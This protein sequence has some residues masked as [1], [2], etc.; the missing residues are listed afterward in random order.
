MIYS[1]RKF[2]KDFD[3]EEN[4]HWIIMS[5][6]LLGIC[7]ALFGKYKA[8]EYL[9]NNP[10]TKYILEDSLSIKKDSI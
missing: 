4:I 6:A 7:F 10:D 5:I 3:V 8:Q 2:L 1:I 9:K